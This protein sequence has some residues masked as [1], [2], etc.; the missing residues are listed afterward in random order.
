MS[1]LKYLIPASFLA[2]LPTLSF[3]GSHGGNLDPSD[4][5]VISFWIIS[6]AM[7]ANMTLR[8]M[9]IQHECCNTSQITMTLSITNSI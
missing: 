2:L 3:A 9:V 8:F 6:I 4:A 7:A 5:V 1:F